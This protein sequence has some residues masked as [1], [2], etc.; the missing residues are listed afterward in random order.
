MP[1]GPT[2]VNQMPNEMPA[3]RRYFRRAEAAVYITG[4]YGFPC[5]RQWLAKL[6]VVGGGPRFRKA[7]RYP[8]YSPA[9]LDDWALSRIGPVQSSTSDVSATSQHS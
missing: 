4:K 9:D 2:E 8:I 3:G 1:A 6:A 7:G 5:S